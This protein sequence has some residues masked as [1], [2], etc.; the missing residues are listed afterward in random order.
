MFSN[1]QFS[2]SLFIFKNFIATFPVDKLLIVL[3]YFNLTLRL[4]NLWKA[5]TSLSSKF[6][7]I[8][9]I[10]EITVLSKLL[11]SMESGIPLLKMLF[12]FPYWARELCSDSSLSIFSPV[13]YIFVTNSDFLPIDVWLLCRLNYVSHL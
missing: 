1:I 9:D 10:M 4:Q 2:Y 8:S 3:L 11:L 6:T 7:F 13:C 12:F 5:F